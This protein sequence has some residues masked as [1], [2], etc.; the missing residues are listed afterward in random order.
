MLK[1][2]S[3]DYDLSDANQRVE[4]WTR[5]ANYKLQGK[6]IARALYVEDRD[7]GHMLALVLST[8][9]TFFPM[10][11]DEGNAPGALHFGEGDILP[12]MR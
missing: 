3:N 12:V 1:P 5:Y 10:S 6:T 4:F 9:E 7:F 8:G 2:N 11:D